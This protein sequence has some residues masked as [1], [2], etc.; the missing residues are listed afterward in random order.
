[1]LSLALS[2]MPARA[3]D[4]A[5][6]HPNLARRA[7]QYYNQTA[8]EKLTDE[9]IDLMAQGAQAEDD[10]AW[11]SLNHFYDPINDSG[12]AIVPDLPLGDSLV[13][14]A[15]GQDAELFRR[16][17]SYTQ[18]LLAGQ[19][20]DL[21]TAY[22]QLGAAL[23]LVAD[24]GMPAHVRNDE[25]LEGDA[26]ESWVKWQAR[27][28]PEAMRLLYIDGTK[29]DCADFG[30]CLRRLALSTNRNY[31]SSDTIS[32]DVYYEP[33][34]S[35]TI[36][37]EG[38]A[39][40]NNHVVAHYNPLLGRLEFNQVV[41]WEYWHALAP[42]IVLYQV[43]VIELFK[44]QSGL[45]PPPKKEGVIGSGVKIQA[46]PEGQIG[47]G[48]KIYNT[49]DEML[50]PI[51]VIDESR[52]MPAAFRLPPG[53]QPA[54]PSAGPAEP[55][56]PAAVLADPVAQPKSEVA[57][58]PAVENPINAPTPPAVSVSG[59][60]PASEPIV[61]LPAPTEAS[62]T[63]STTTSS[64]PTSTPSAVETPPAPPGPV[65]QYLWLF[66]EGSGTVAWENAG[67]SAIRTYADWAEG[68]SGFCL[69]SSFETQKFAFA[70]RDNFLLA[71]D[72]TIAFDVKDGSE[73]IS[74]DT[75][76]IVILGGMFSE[77][78]GVAPSA[79]QIAYYYN[80]VRHNFT[81]AL[82]DDR[83]WH[84][85]AI[86]YSASSLKLYLDGSLKE[87]VDGDFRLPAGAV[88]LRIVGENAPAYIDNLAIW[89]QALTP[90]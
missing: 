87:V 37:A 38:Y 46:E 13:E 2:A 69:K 7:A 82:P 14:W 18:A 31:F 49:E 33:Y 15:K 21:A 75:A 27:E 85:L 11:R 78:A 25:H 44:Q 81:S 54:L 64:A 66:D 65:Q 53:Q 61:S 1:M 4:E 16:D 77:I 12:L 35:V 30:D 74:Y 55:A 34:D 26:Y 68:K 47:T 40:A 36:N 84:R 58:A 83:A 5:I 79:N 51:P 80:G 24:A 72:L 89:S 3:Y 6:T 23:H 10:P 41:L 20:K 73:A 32:D 43:R 57:P 28:N 70:Q 48:L 22:R 67:G 71:G 9:Q 19:R 90:N 45:T 52:D 56:L 8:K 60:T 42:Q 88:Q 63:A 76:R 17:D 59:Q 50:W 29:P 86:V 62:T 39:V